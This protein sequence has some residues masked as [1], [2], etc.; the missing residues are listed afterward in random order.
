LARLAERLDLG[1]RLEEVNGEAGAVII[2]SAD[3][4]VSVMA[5]EIAEGSVHA[6]RSV[7]NPDKLRHLGP[8]ANLGVLLN[9]GRVQ[10]T[11][12]DSAAA[13]AKTAP[14]DRLR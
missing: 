5:L 11:P 4:V 14:V 12:G 10:P 13:P 9:S 6:I 3:R 8:V 7:V 1:V 2:D